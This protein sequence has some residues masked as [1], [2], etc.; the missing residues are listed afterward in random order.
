MPE[1]DRRTVL[2]LGALVPVVGLV[3]GLAAPAE[4]AASPYSRS[5]WSPHVGKTFAL[6]WKGG[7]ATAVLVAIG[8]LTG[9]P[10]GAVTRFSLDLRVASGG[11]PTGATTLSRNGFGSVSLF[12]SPVD[13]GVTDIHALAVVNR[14]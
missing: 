12:L 11:T 7:T 5:T 4:A 10:A 13:R 6:S 8:D 3:T 1:L 14:L 9:A 2:R